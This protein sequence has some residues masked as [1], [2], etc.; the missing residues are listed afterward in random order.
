M[1]E[2]SSNHY[3]HPH[4]PPFPFLCASSRLLPLIKKKTATRNTDALLSALN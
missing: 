2:N 3:T 4:P 1:K